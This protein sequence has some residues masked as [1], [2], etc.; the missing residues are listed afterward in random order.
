[1]TYLSDKEYK[2]P[3][4]GLAQFVLMHH[5][6]FELLLRSKLWQLSETLVQATEIL[7]LCKIQISMYLLY[8]KL[9]KKQR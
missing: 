8:T 7:V 9:Q 1:M 3:F 6:L 5:N 2:Y 4:Y